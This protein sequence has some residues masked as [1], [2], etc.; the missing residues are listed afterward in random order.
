MT[1]S[2]LQPTTKLKIE[3]RLYILTFTGECLGDPIRHMP[4]IQ[5]QCQQ[6]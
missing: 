1:Y 5:G 2:A 6:S 4:G 3:S